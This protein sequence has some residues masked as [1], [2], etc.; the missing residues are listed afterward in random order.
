MRQR[1]K[2]ILLSLFICIALIFVIIVQIPTNRDTSRLEDQGT[3]FTNTENVRVEL[4]HQLDSSDV[5][6]TGIGYVRLPLKVASTT[7]GI[8]YSE[9]VFGIEALDNGTELKVYRAGD[10]VFTGVSG[11][12]PPI[13]NEEVVLEKANFS[14]VLTNYT[15]QW[16]RQSGDV[17]EEIFTLHHNLDGTVLAT[18]DCNV[19]NGT[20][21]ITKVMD[22]TY[23]IQTSTLRDC[24][25]HINEIKFI[26]AIKEANKIELTDSMKLVLKNNNMQLIILEAQLIPLL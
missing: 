21:T 11:M 3:Y 12:L 2:Y 4:L 14:E 23:N 19:F 5:L 1:T 26:K 25:S 9:S 22:I 13:L 8:K 18:T 24:E 20:Y 17:D 6:F 10:L 16:S 15:W 7:A